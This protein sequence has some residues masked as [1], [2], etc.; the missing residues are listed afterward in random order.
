M[1]NY[2]IGNGP[3]AIIKVWDKQTLIRIKRNPDLLWCGNQEGNVGGS[4]QVL[5][6]VAGIH[7]NTKTLRIV[8]PGKGEW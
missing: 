7:D 4:I 5:S 3:E 2:F 6:I 1:N 8:S